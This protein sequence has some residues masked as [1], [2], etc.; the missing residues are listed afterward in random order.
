M[1]KIS[2]FTLYTP[3]SL[4]MIQQKVGSESGVLDLSSPTGYRKWDAQ[5][6]ELIVSK[7]RSPKPDRVGVPV[8]TL[9]GMYDPIQ[10]SEMQS[11]IYPALYG[12]WGNVF[13]PDT[14]RNSDPALVQ[15]RCSLEV[16]HENGKTYRFPLNDEIAAS[17]VK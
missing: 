1:G 5:K 14:T 13:S 16:T 11:F 15:S 2:V 17:E 7:V 10:P 9:V 4:N 3:F 8:M 6:Q 12:N